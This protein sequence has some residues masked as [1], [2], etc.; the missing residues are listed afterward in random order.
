[1]VVLA[2]E[3][4]VRVDRMNTDIRKYLSI[5]Q[6]LG[7]FIQSLLI[8]VGFIVTLF[9]IYSTIIS[10]IPMNVFP[11]LILLVSYIFII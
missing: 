2:N 3:H 6:R 5:N 1:M 4:P 11:F 9:T 10:D 7:L 8:I